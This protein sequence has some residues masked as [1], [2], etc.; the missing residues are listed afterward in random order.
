MAG[1]D[2]VN[3]GSH[4]EWRHFVD[5]ARVAITHQPL[6]DSPKTTQNEN[7]QFHMQ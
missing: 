6:A 5:D 2:G 4:D 1:I 3:K 7:A